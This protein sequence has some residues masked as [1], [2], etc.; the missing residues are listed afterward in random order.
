MPWASAEAG[1]SDL[2]GLVTSSLMVL[3]MPFS[4][5]QIGYLKAQDAMP[6][7]YFEPKIAFS[8]QFDARNLIRFGA[9]S[10]TLVDTLS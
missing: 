2:C 4:G 9:Y 6:W 10:R 8:R 3:F 1:V 7:I 5:G